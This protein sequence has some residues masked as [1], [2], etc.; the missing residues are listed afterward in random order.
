[1]DYY[2]C[3]PYNIFIYQCMNKIVFNNILIIAHIVL[4]EHNILQLGKQEMRM[5]FLKQL[6]L[7]YY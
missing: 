1:M 2:I 6:K 7:A 4:S 5:L 3:K